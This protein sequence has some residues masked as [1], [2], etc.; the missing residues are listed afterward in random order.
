MK[1]AVRNLSAA[2]RPISGRAQAG[3]RSESGP[4]E[5]VALLGP[6]GAGNRR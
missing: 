2:M 3:L 4:A 5:T 6:N 1:L